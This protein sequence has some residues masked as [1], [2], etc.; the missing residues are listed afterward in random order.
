MQTYTILFDEYRPGDKLEFSKFPNLNVIFN[1][2][3]NNLCP[4]YYKSDTVCVSS[5]YLSLTL[6]VNNKKVILTSK[7]KDSI[8]IDGYKIKGLDHIVNNKSYD[9]TFMIISIEKTGDYQDHQ[10][11]QD[12]QDNESYQKPKIY[13]L[14]QPFIIEFHENRSTGYV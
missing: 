6:T 1:E 12:Y 14:G 3:K 7:M 11:H 4:S 10:D 5:G 9:Q 8:N 2:N 13:N